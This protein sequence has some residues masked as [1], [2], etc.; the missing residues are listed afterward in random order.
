MNKTVRDCLVT[1]F[2]PLIDALELPDPDDRHVLAAAIK[3]RAQVIVT[4]NLKDFPLA[5]LEPW[6]MEAKSPD[7]FILDQ[8]DLGRETVYGA[9]Q[10][11]AD[12]MANPPATVADV[13]AMLERDGLVES[14]AALRP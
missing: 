12:A 4:N 7:D 8:I 3:A 10:R 6:D 11:I 1:G 2:E 14:S 5:A 13:L 9:V